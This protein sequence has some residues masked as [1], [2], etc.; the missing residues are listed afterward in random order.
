[1][2]TG[3]QA[4]IDSWL[5]NS[6]FLCSM[7]PESRLQLLLVRN[8]L[9]LR[10][11][12]LCKKRLIKAKLGRFS[13]S[14]QTFYCLLV[15]PWLFWRNLH[16]MEST[17]LR[18]QIWVSVKPNYFCERARFWWNLRQAEVFGPKTTQTTFFPAQRTQKPALTGLRK[19]NFS[20]F[21]KMHFWP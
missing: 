21:W 20:V 18:G 19:V 7:A 12:L 10:N 8:P 17:P 4:E 3:L 14:L 6:L 13:I 9:P 1:M 2:L 15:F 5:Q 11:Q 16:E